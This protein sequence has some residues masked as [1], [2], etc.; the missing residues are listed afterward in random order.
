MVEGVG[1]EGVGVV[2]GSGIHTLN[3]SAR[4]PAAHH[5]RVQVHESV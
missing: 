1:V 2:S 3:Q 5:R 4:A